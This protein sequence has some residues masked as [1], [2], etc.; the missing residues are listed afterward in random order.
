MEGAGSGGGRAEALK[1][2]SPRGKQGAQLSVTSSPHSPW[3]PAG[4]TAGR[5]LS[6]HMLSK[7]SEVTCLSLPSRLPGLVSMETR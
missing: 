3:G 1:C 5:V 2:W 4:G 7:T 6:E